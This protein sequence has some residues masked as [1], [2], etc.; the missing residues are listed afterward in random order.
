MA[1]SARSGPCPKCGGKAGFEQGAQ[2]CRCGQC[3]ALCFTG[4]AG[5]LYSDA[6]QYGDTR[7]LKHL[8]ERL[9]ADSSL[10]SKRK[11]IIADDLGPAT[12]TRQGDLLGPGP[13][14]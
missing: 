1:R 5:G 13:P 12:E 10:G 4:S 14:F 3:G 9:R 7:R 6:V 8:A 2:V 11:P